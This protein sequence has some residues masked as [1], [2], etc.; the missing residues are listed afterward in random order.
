MF[1]TVGRFRYPIEP[2][3]AVLSV[4]FLQANVGRSLDEADSIGGNSGD[5]GVEKA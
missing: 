4:L 5:R 2:V 3:C 1:F